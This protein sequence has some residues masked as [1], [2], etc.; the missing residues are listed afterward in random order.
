MVWTRMKGCRMVMIHNSFFPAILIKFTNF[1]S[2][3]LNQFL[4]ACLILIFSTFRRFFIIHH[5]GISL[6]G[7]WVGYVW[8]RQM[9]AGNYIV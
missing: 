5:P 6:F 8:S 1:I 2:F 9:S 3:L 4:F 7:C